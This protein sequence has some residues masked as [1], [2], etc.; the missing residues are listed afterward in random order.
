M[1]YSFDGLTILLT[2]GAGYIGSHTCV[3]LLASGCKVVVVD[4]LV[5]SSLIA[6]K[7]VAAIAG[8]TLSTDPEVPADMIFYEVDVCDENSLKVV[9]GRHNIDAVIHFAGLKAVGESV[10]A[11]LGYYR[12]NVMGSIALLQQM[13]ESN[14]KTL[15][16]SSSAT[17]YGA[18]SAMPIT[19]SFNTGN[20]T[21]P[22]V[23]LNLL[24]SR[25]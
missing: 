17:V 11:P 16:F 9:F 19:E 7:R 20:T 2:G 8:K 23:S 1:L 6:L 5:N 13:A 14:V 24:S 25:F 3:E 21:S 10:K 18:T 22:T 12:N 4:N 15:V